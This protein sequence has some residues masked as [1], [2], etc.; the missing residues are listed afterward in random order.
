MRTG[1]SQEISQTLHQTLKQ[2]MKL[3]YSYNWVLVD[4]QK[5]N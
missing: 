2:G 4:C 1:Q 5:K 3:E